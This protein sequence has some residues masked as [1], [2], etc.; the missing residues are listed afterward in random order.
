MM[1]GTTAKSLRPSWS[2]LKRR[3]NLGPAQRCAARLRDV[4]ARECAYGHFADLRGSARTFGASFGRRGQPVR[5][6]WRSD[7][8]AVGRVRSNG[9]TD[10]VYRV[11]AKTFSSMRGFNVVQTTVVAVPNVEAMP[12]VPTPTASGSGSTNPASGPNAVAVTCRA[13][14]GAGAVAACTPAPCGAAAARDQGAGP[15]RAQPTGRHAA[16]HTGAAWMTRTAKSWT[17]RCVHRSPSCRSTHHT[18]RITTTAKMPT[19][20]SPGR[21]RSSPTRGRCHPLSPTTPSTIAS[22]T[23]KPERLQRGSPVCRRRCVAARARDQV[24]CAGCLPWHDAC[25][26]T[27]AQQ[28]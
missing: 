16:G 21:C 9:T 25:V 17:M 7:G 13:V 6:G 26:S 22:S 1:R 3:S 14:P 4:H 11:G 8:G 18:S 2:N 15:R 24:F 10:H 27:A 20:P 28:G 23:P 19:I 5:H 12:T